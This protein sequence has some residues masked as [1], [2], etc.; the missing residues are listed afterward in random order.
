MHQETLLGQ[1]NKKLAIAKKKTINT[2][3]CKQVRI[4]L[5]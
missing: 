5:N 2:I 3:E 1:S 4:F